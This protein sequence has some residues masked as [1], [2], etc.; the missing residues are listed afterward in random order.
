M[1]TPAILTSD[2]LPRLSLTEWAQAGAGTVSASSVVTPT[3][4]TQPFRLQS[5]QVLR[6]VTL[7]LPSLKSAI[8]NGTWGDPYG[9]KYG[10]G[11]IIVEGATDWVIE[12]C[13]FEAINYPKYVH[14][15]EEGF[16][17]IHVIGGSSNGLIRRCTFKHMDTA[18]F[19]RGGSHHITVED[20]VIESSRK[21]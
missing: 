9:Y 18:I 16:N 2:P 14:N 1:T 8:G 12:D 7:K 4:L 10:G 13:V 17:V 20:C 3:A 19:L 21:S 15:S 5:G 11:W 6:G